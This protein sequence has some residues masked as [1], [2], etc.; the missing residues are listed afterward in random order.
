LLIL[1]L[2]GG[3]AILFLM[4]MMKAAVPHGRQSV[5]ISRAEAPIANAILQKAENAEHGRPAAAPLVKPVRGGTDKLLPLPDSGISAPADNSLAGEKAR[6]VKGGLDTDAV[7]SQKTTQVPPSKTPIGGS[8][9]A[10]ASL[11]ARRRKPGK[12]SAPESKDRLRPKEIV[13]AE[14]KFKYL[15]LPSG[16]RSGSSWFVDAFT[17]AGGH[18]A[19][20]PHKWGKD[21]E[22]K[23][24]KQDQECLRIRSGETWIDFARR[25]W[26]AY[27]ISGIKDF[28]DQGD[29]LKFGTKHGDQFAAL[30]KEL[31]VFVV[32]LT[33]N[34]EIAQAISQ[35]KV[36]QEAEFSIKN[37]LKCRGYNLYTSKCKVDTGK[38]TKATPESVIDVAAN[39]MMHV[40][41]Q[42][43]FLVYYKL[44]FTEIIYE[45]AVLHT[46]RTIEK[47][48]GEFTTFHKRCRGMFLARK[49]HP[50]K[51][52][53]A[54]VAG[55]SKVLGGRKQMDKLAK[56]VFGMS[57]CVG[58][59][60]YEAYP[61]SSC[62]HML[63][64]TSGGK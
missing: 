4:P 48:C 12:K 17:T 23:F 61:K 15:V 50:P 3:A 34:N 27:P 52:N 16:M 14:E 55:L 60:F 63:Q 26:L 43:E 51:T 2:V 37:N 30:L 36:D 54:Y 64:R 59:Q 56:K 44:P 46:N 8:T 20:E 31:N 53:E 40:Y 33:R 7:Q 24:R 39:T 10:P 49:S 45:E 21:L 38:R 42:I 35:L 25:I 13:A 11:T 6:N 28:F 57:K 41:R 58:S 32:L 47:L 9:V 19:Y 1:L 18:C 62:R 5:G 29:Y 22:C